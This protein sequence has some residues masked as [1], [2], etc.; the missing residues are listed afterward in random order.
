MAELAI[1]MRYLGIAS[2][3]GVVMALAFMGLFLPGPRD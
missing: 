3:I 1:V 2:I